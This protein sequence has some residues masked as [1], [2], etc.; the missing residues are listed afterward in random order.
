MVMSGQLHVAASLSPEKE[1]TEQEAQLAPESV[2]SVWKRHKCLA[3]SGIRMPYRPDGSVLTLALRSGSKRWWITTK[4]T[5]LLVQDSV[6]QSFWYRGHLLQNP[7]NSMGSLPRFIS[8]R[9]PLRHTSWYDLQI[10][11]IFKLRSPLWIQC[12]NLIKKYN[13]STNYDN[14]A[15]TRNNL[16]ESELYDLLGAKAIELEHPRLRNTMV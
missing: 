5:W 6:S 1:P 4:I 14:Y 10:R 9:R 16:N 13:F 7:I 2:R 15:T 8:N 3:S 12:Q 11:N